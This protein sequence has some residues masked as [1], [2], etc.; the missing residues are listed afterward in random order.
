MKY[1]VSLSE[2]LGVFLYSVG[3]GFLSGIFYRIV[4][5]LREAASR[6]KSAV[7]A[8]DIIFSVFET[9]AAY[10][11]LIVFSGGEFRFNLLCGSALG[12]YMYQK[13]LDRFLSPVFG[14]IFNIIFSAVRLLL[15]PFKLFFGKAAKTA[16]LVRQKAKGAFEKKRA[17]KACETPEN[18]EKDGSKKK[19]KRIRKLFV[20]TDLKSSEESV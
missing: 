17:E 4:M 5:L 9:V 16:S 12:F 2:Q 18:A 8:G 1:I 10:C 14:K 19:N 15:R 13:T 6:K 11:F 7:I 20:K 3:F